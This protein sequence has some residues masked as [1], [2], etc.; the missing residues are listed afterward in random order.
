MV[1]HRHGRLCKP[2][3]TSGLGVRNSILDIATRLHTDCGFDKGHV[4]MVQVVFYEVPK[5]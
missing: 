1:F 4:I 2:K 3:A 5:S